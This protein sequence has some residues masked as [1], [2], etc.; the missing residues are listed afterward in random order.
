MLCVGNSADASIVFVHAANG[1]QRHVVGSSSP[2][3]IAA[4]TTE[5]N[6]TG[7]APTTE[8]AVGRKIV[9]L[10]LQGGGSHG[11]FT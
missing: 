2:A 10:A 9:N 8:S 5:Q 7:S 4:M 11:A 3:F 6:R 1:R